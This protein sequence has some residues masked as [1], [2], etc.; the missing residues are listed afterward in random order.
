[1]ERMNEWMNDSAFMYRFQ[2]CIDYDDD[3]EPQATTAE[4]IYIVVQCDDRSP[5]SPIT[6]FP[7][8]VMQQHQLL[9]HPLPPIHLSPAASHFLLSFQ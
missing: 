3:D 7:D 5:I 8:C 1:M 9:L 6:H 2:H 4:R